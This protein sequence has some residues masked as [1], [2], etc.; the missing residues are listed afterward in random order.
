MSTTYAKLVHRHRIALRI[1]KAFVLAVAI[2]AAAT[3]SPLL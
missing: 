1:E 3:L 2:I